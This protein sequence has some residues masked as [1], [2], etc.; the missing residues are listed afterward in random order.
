[1]IP[2]LA[3][4]LLGVVAI[5]ALLRWRHW[6][7]AYQRLV[8][9]IGNDTDVARMEAL[10]RHFLGRSG[11]SYILYLRDEQAEVSADTLRDL[12]DRAIAIEMATSSLATA[13]TAVAAVGTFNSEDT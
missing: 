5:V 6:R 3:I 13:R 7:L 4:L 12:A 9:D 8:A 10:S 2:T 11:S 1:M